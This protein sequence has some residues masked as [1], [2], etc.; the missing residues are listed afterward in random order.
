[1][2]NSSL[3]TAVGGAV[4]R[5]IA[6]IVVIFLIY[7]G[8]TFCYD[9]GYR[10]FAEPAISAGEGRTVTVTITE[11]M[12]PQEIG[13]LLLSKGLIRDDKLF[14]IQY[15]LSEFQKEVKPGVFELSTAMTVEEMM[16]VMAT[17][18]AETEDNTENNT[19]ENTQ[20]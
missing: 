20:E 8:A 14:V 7:R 3:V 12:S 10:I 5:V 2:K 6:V 18:P 17:A 19:D 15:Y 4:F 11:D 9:Y 16:E 13:T 1:M